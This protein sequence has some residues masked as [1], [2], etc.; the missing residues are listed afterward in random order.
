MTRP[1]PATSTRQG[2]DSTVMTEEAFKALASSVDRRVTWGAGDQLGALHFLTAAATAAAAQEV[3]AGSVISCAARSRGALT[4]LTTSIDGSD[5]WSAV[6]ETLVIQQH[7][8]A[9][10]THF[11]GLGHFFYEGRSHAG[12]PDSVVGPAG[13]TSLDVV[14]ASGGIVG[15]GLLLDLPAI[16]GVPYLGLDRDV[17][18]AEVRAWL[19]RRGVGPR[20]GDILFVRTGALLAPLA[21]VG[22]PAVGGL[23]LDCV[24]WVFDQQFSVI[25]SD[26]GLDSPRSMVERVATPWHILLIA[27]MGVSLVDFADLEALGATCAALDRV[28]FLAS[29]AVLPL[30]GSTASPVNPVAVL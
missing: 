4:S 25:V 2:A 29:I 26:A 16:A 3:R 30:A 11:D 21:P 19:D 1:T 8:P 5:A 24:P 9:S 14:P 17:R 22:L 6:N 28:T 7:G 20:P 12:T 13:V 15:R 27:R 23:D 18:L 10:M